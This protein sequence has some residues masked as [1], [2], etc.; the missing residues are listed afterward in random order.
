MTA[1]SCHPQK[2][3]WRQGR[4]NGGRRFGRVVGRK[5]CQL[6]IYEI[7]PWEQFVMFLVGAWLGYCSEDV[8]YGVVGYKERNTADGISVDRRVDCGEGPGVG[9]ALGPTVDPVGASGVRIV[10]STI[11]ALR[12]TVYP[13]RNSHNQRLQ[14]LFARVW[15]A[16]T[17][18][19]AVQSSYGVIHILVNG[20]NLIAIRRRWPS[21]MG[22]QGG[23]KEFEEGIR[24]MKEL[25]FKFTCESYTSFA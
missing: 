10:G 20:H 17:L 6:G 22:K 3:P 23:G 11:T 1:L 21:I 18:H 8:G 2:L 5:E 9:P 24:V 7:V 15:I 14:G 4:S 19:L 16:Q 12:Q 25:L 13:Q